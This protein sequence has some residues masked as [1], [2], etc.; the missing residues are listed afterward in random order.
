MRFYPGISP[1]PPPCAGGWGGRRGQPSSHVPCI[2]WMQ[3]LGHAPPLPTHA[4][5]SPPP[6][7]LWSYPCASNSRDGPHGCRPTRLPPPTLLAGCHLTTVL[8]SCGMKR[9]V[10]SMRQLCRGVCVE[11]GRSSGSGSEGCRREKGCS[12]VQAG[13]GWVRTGCMRVRGGEG[14]GCSRVRDGWGW[15]HE[16]AGWRGVQ[17]GAGWVQGGCMRVR[18]G[19]GGG[20]EGAGA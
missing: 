8:V 11:R 14:G 2:R 9:R 18:G 4:A 17:E 7:S 16:G 10:K 1:P 3:R 20:H 19:E 5:A 13:V 15:V 12:S 6:A